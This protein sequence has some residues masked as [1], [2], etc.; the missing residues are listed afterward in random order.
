MNKEYKNLYDKN[1][2]FKLYVDKWCKKSNISVEEAL[3][4]KVIQNYAEHL[5]S[6]DLEGFIL[7]KGE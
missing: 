3:E 4:I 2:D 1:E 7:G 5:N 6:K